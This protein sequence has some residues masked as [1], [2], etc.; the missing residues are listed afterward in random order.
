MST[1]QEKV[2]TAKNL[3]IS[4]KKGKLNLHLNFLTIFHKKFASHDYIPQFYS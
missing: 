3:Y 4:Q 2:A 1:K